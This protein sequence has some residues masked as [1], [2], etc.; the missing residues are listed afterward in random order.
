MAAAPM[1]SALRSTSH[2]PRPPTLSPSRCLTRY[3]PVKAQVQSVTQQSSTADALAAPPPTPSETTSS[4]TPRSGIPRRTTPPPDLPRSS[5]AFFDA[6]GI[7]WVGVG[8]EQPPDPN[9]AK[10]GRSKLRHTNKHPTLQEHSVLTTNSNSPPHP[11]GPPP[12]PLPVATPA[13]HP[14]PQHLPPPLPVHPPPPPDRLRPRRLQ[15]RP[16]DLAHRL[17]QG[18]PLRQRPA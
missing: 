10:L 3:N 1:R 16:L 13:G 14:R 11:P 15:R 12:K 18:A 9:K 6:T 5:K 2:H 17:E 7:L 4:H 8:D